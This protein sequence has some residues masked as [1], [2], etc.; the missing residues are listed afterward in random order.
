MSFR[1]DYTMPPEDVFTKFAA[2]TIVEEQD[3]SLLSE[4]ERFGR[5]VKLPY[6]VPDWRAPPAT[7]PLSSLTPKRPF[8]V[9]RRQSRQTEKTELRAGG[10][11][12]LRGT[13]IDT[14]KG[15]YY[16][17]QF[18]W[19]LIMPDHVRSLDWGH[20]ARC[21]W[22]LLE[23]HLGY[24]IDSTYLPTK[25]PVIIALLRTITVDNFQLL[26]YLLLTKRRAT[27]LYIA[28]S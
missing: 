11:L 9:I 18:K 5:D 10:K 8:N 21:L 14:V 22:E 6:W 26:L 20:T 3:I 7:N 12:S 17:D 23:V 24:S 25:E 16:L 1:S 27:F 2:K 4:C 28:A 13:H 19:A 15:V